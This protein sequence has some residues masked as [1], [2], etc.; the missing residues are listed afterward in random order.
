[1]KCRSVRQPWA[2]AILHGG[3]D[4]ENRN[5]RTHYRGPLA[6]HAGKQFDM[7][8]SDFADYTR[9][10][11]GE[12]WLGMATQFIRQYDCIGNEPRGAII[13]VVDL[14]DCLPSFRCRSPWK[15]GDDP[16]YYCWQLAN[17]RPLAEPIPY[18]GAL[19]LFELPADIVTILK[20]VTHAQG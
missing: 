9:G 12:P 6:I 11:F 10:L 5:W 8:E 4:I 17:P 3:K 15:A 19:G 13:G 14:V 1:M 18:K 16:D 20:E 2:W 7:S